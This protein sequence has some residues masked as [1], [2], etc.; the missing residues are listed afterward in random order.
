MHLLRPRETV[1]SI[2][3]IDFERLLRQGMT[4]ILFDLDQTLK[5]RR[6]ADMEPAVLALLERLDTIGLR[7]GIL[8]NR[9]HNGDPLLDTLGDRYPL[10]HTARK[11]WKRGFLSLLQEL[12][13]SPQ[14]AVMVGDRLL[15][16]VFG[17]NRLGIY[18]I[19]VLPPRRR[20]RRGR[21]LPA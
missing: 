16:D 21:H 2:L 6:V 8:T 19:R 17:A 13:A 18:S 3:E 10:R 1:R 12:G 9:R 5:E 15:T 7:V 14:Q 4:T 20:P 11:P